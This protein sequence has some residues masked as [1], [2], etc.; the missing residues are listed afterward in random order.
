VPVVASI[1]WNNT[2]TATDNDL[3]GAPIPKSGGHL[4]VVSGFTRRGDVIVADPAAATNA[5]VRRTYAR[6]QFERNWLN[7]STGT[8]YVIQP[9]D[10]K[11][12]TR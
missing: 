3:S 11:R 2:D 9:V 10:H 7:A 8:T 12:S 5:T 1:A 6:A 4:L